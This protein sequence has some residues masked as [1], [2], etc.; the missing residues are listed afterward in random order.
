MSYVEGATRSF[1]AN[2]AL[3]RYLR[4]KLNGSNKL[5]VAVAADVDEELGTIEQAATAADEYVPVRLRTAQGTRHMI[6]SKAIAI[7]DDI[8]T[9]AGGKVTDTSAT[10]NFKI[11]KALTAASGDGSVI[12]VLTHYAFTAAE[13]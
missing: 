5:V 3:G 12:E 11:G 2:A 10:G 13:A 1:Q 6:A 9:D 7:N 4:V 8:Y